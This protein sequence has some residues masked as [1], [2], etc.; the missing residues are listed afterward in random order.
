MRGLTKFVFCDMVL[1]G[2]ITI[3][4]GNLI[5]SYGKSDADPTSDAETAALLATGKVKEWQTARVVPPTAAVVT[6]DQFVAYYRVSTDRQGRYPD[7]PW[8]LEIRR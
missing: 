4:D 2:E 3:A 8:A 1:R 6:I 5:I 7:P